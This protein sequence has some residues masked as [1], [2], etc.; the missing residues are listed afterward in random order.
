MPIS[1]PENGIN[2]DCASFG[3]SAELSDNTGCSGS[4]GQQGPPGAN[5]ANGNVNYIYT[6]VGAGD[7]NGRISANIGDGFKDS[8][9]LFWV[10]KFGG[11]NWGYD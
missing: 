1:C 11:T 6:Q 8:D 5:G 9:G 3:I 10:N 4:Q 7:P 2:C